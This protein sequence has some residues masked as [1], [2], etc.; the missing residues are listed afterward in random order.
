MPGLDDHSL[1]HRTKQATASYKQ[2][3]IQ[4]LANFSP[5]M[6]D[7]PMIIIRRKKCGVNTFCL[8]RLSLYLLEK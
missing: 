2:G 4:K 5:T 6:N 3:G 7:H 8:N 1:R